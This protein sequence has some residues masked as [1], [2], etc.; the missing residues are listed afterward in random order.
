MA[1][2]DVFAPYKFANVPELHTQKRSEFIK[3]ITHTSWLANFKML[4]SF[5]M[6]YFAA[7]SLQKHAQE[8]NKNK[9]SK[10]QQ[11]FAV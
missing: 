9:L 6:A 7:Q 2:A 4:G 3:K 1:A 11:I 5:I 10:C 8:D